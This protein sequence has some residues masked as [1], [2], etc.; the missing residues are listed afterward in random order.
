MQA[1]KDPLLWSHGFDGGPMLITLSVQ[2]TQHHLPV[3]F[4]NVKGIGPL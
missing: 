3:T 1:A 4:L 2:R